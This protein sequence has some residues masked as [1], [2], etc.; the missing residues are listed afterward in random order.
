MKRI[1]FLDG[2]RGVAIMLVI[3]FH[4]FARWPE[5]V[6]YHNLYSDFFLFKYGY[7]GV[8]LFFL[9]S[10]F[11]ILMTLERTNS[12]LQFIYKRWLRLFPAMFI[13][14]ILI[15]ITSQFLFERPAGIPPLKSILPGL[16]FI[17]P[18]WIHLISGFEI[19]PIEG[20]FWSLFVEFK[21]YFVFGIMYFMLGKKNAILGIF[22]MFV[23]SIIGEKFNIKLLMILSNAFSFMYFDWFVI[24]SLVYMY[25]IDKKVKYLYFSFLVSMIEFYQCIN[26]NEYGKLMFLISILIVFITPVYF[27]KT[28]FLLK[29]KLLLFF[30]LVSYPLYLIHENAM[31]SLIIK[32]NKITHIPY[33]LLPVIPIIVLLIISL[34]IVKVFEPFVLKMIKKATL[35][36]NILKV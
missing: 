17:D 27:E 12:F 18:R 21:F 22:S 23:L 13:A 19:S 32:L 9:I 7:L 30:G 36:I 28:R 33:I 14:T 11:V 20:A 2:L 15:Y 3:L 35:N 29:N 16:L 24:G 8:Q 31:I 4:A 1:E 34:F 6:P 26:H 5:I 25:Y 10:G